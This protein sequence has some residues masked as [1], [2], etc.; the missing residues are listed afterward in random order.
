MIGWKLNMYYKRK[1]I[2]IACD[3]KSF[4][5]VYSECSIMGYFYIPVGYQWLNLELDKMIENMIEDL[6]T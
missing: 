1:T 2:D 3:M 5:K 6:C 4:S